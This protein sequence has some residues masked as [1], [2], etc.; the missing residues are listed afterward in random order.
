M[1][2]TPVLRYG[3]EVGISEGLSLPAGKHCAQLCSGMTGRPA[4]SPPRR[5]ICSYVWRLV[6]ASAH[7]GQCPHRTARSAFVD[8]WFDAMIATLRECPEIGV[9]VCTVLDGHRPGRR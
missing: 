5:T 9:G 6:G 8:G 1:S 7:K 4:V 3:E 2:G